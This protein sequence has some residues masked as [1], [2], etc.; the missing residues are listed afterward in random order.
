MFA[1]AGLDFVQ[2]SL[3]SLQLHQIQNAVHH[4]VNL[5]APDIY[6]QALP[7]I[8][9]NS[10]ANIYGIVRVEDKDKGVHGQIKS[11]EI[12]DGDPD[13]HFRIRPTN[14]AGEYNIEI[15]RLLDRETTP[16]G[17]NLTL[18]AIDRGIPPKSGK[19]FFCCAFYIVAS[20]GPHEPENMY[21]C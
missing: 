3:L 16:Q 13:G 2:F 11:L 8:T 15:H 9:E 12:V 18:R 21:H 5:Y 6:V 7:D 4:Q 20:R 10:N 14:K 1:V 17:Y 19:F